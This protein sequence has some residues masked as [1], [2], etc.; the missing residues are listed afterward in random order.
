MTPQ[1]S[2]AARDYY[3]ALVVYYRTLRERST[4]S[5]EDS[6]ALIFAANDVGAARRRVEAFALRE[7]ETA[8]R[9][10]GT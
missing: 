4:G 7:A 8:D 10:T 6:T 2:A 9:S 1:A 5:L 3:D